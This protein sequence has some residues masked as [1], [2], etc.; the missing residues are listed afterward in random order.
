MLVLGSA[1]GAVSI[2]A[3]AAPTAAAQPTWLTCAGTQSATYSPPITF[4]ARLT[5]VGLSESY[6]NCV[7]NAGIVAGNVAFTVTQSANCGLML[8]SSA[9]VTTYAWNNGKTSTVR[10]STTEVGRLV[11]GSTVVTSIGSVTG[12]F[13]QGAMAIRALTTVPPNPLLCFTTGVAQESGPVS[14]T[15]LS[16]GGA[17]PSAK[18][19]P[20]RHHVRHV[21]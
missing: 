12:G 15:F 5:T 11:N 7:D 17:V 16:A 13:G 8:T 2:V 1:A 20:E 18:R 10:F 3:L 9:P 21:R 19:V 4:T 6:S 14:L